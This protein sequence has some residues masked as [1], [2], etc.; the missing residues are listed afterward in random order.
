MTE[1]A[2][3]NKQ[4]HKDFSIQMNFGLEFCKQDN[5]CPLVLDEIDR[6]A[7]EAPII[8]V[9]DNQNKFN[10]CMLLGFQPQ[11]NVFLNESNRWIGGYVPAIYRSYPFALLKDEK[12]DKKILCYDTRSGVIVKNPS[13]ESKKLFEKDG[14]N[15][16]FLNSIL[17]FVTTLDEKKKSTFVAIEMINEYKLFEKWELKLKNKEKT[18]A[19]RGLWK[20]SKEKFEKLDKEQFSN[21]RDIG[22]LPMIYGHFISLYNINKLVTSH[23]L[24]QGGAR[25]LV[26]RTKEKQAKASKEKVDTL[27]QNLL[28]DD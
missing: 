3:I 4:K 15:T 26:D 5:Y 1:Y 23:T 14:T 16:D 12:T 7:T 27:V 21:L 22:C 2:P 13:G 9:A 8:F 24:T 17:N 18:E 25:T 20:I 19:I 10:L 6:A 28:M 11:K